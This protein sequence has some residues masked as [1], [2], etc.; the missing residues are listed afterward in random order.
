MADSSFS[1]PLEPRELGTLIVVVGKAVRLRSCVYET[2]GRRIAS[3]AVPWRCRGDWGLSACRRAPRAAGPDRAAD[4]A[5]KLAKQVTV[6]QARSFL[7][8]TRWRGQ[9]ED[10]VYQAVRL[11]LL[12]QAAS[13]Q[14]LP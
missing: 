5:E 8:C 10:Q 14:V 13:R 7:L 2:G 6:R 4:A 9:E 1:D 3:R 11:V 12:H